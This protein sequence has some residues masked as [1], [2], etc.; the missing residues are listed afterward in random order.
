MDTRVNSGDPPIKCGCNCADSAKLYRPRKVDVSRFQ[1]W[2][3]EP[4]CL[5]AKVRRII[6]GWIIFL[7]TLRCSL[8]TM[9]IDADEENRKDQLWACNQSTILGWWFDWHATG[10]PG[11]R[12]QCLSDSEWPL[13]WAWYLQRVTLSQ[14]V[15]RH[16]H[17]NHPDPLY[18]SQGTTSC[19]RGPGAS[20][21]LDS[22]KWSRQHSTLLLEPSELWQLE[23]WFSGNFLRQRAANAMTVIMPVSDALGWAATTRLTVTVPQWALFGPSRAWEGLRKW[24]V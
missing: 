23:Q 8:L 1:R 10:R 4:D 12:A 11:R 24:A 15:K 21:P 22:G 3:A 19:R 7:A 9:T 6:I 20:L 16:N 18:H 14:T 13:D 5:R 2:N 17:Q